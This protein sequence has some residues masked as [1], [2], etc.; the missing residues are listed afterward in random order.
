MAGSSGLGHYVYIYNSGRVPL[1]IVS[2]ACVKAINHRGVIRVNVN[3][4]PCIRSCSAKCH[5]RLGREAMLGSNRVCRFQV[6]N[7]FI[8]CA[9]GNINTASLG[10][11]G[12]N[13][14]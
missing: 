10:R 6:E 4:K 7:N 8:I 13:L 1:Q 3:V 2:F 11:S 5:S 14:K 9:V 12:W